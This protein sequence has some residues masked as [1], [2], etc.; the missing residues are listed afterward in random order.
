[1]AAALLP[2]PAADHA[3]RAAYMALAMIASLERFNERSGDSLQ[4]RVG[5]N[6]GAVV[7][8]VIGK[9]KFIYG[10]W[11]DAVNI[12]SRMESHGMARPGPGDGGRPA[13]AARGVPV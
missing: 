5:I 8:G 12:A 3:V 6:S 4:L 10:L 7:A 9:H 1:M 2:V 13:A 11:G